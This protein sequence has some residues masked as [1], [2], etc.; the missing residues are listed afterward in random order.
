MPDHS[1]PVAADPVR[2]TRLADYRPPAYLVNRVALAFELHETATR[3]RSRLHLRRDTEGNPPLV[4]D[5]AGQAIERITLDGEALGANRY[6]LSPETL[7]IADVPDAFTL[8]IETTINPRDNT[9]LSGLYLSNGGFFTQCE[10]EGF[11]RITYFPDRPDVMA[12]F[13]VT[14]TADA[15]RCPVM[16]SNGNPGAIE[17]LGD[18]RHRVTWTDPHPKPSYLFALVAGDLVRVADSFTTRS[19]RSV[20]LGIWVRRGDEASCGHAMRSLKAAMAWDEEVF[21]L[22]Y[23]L[24]VFNV[25]A[26]S[27]F[28]MGAMENKGLNVF[29]TKYVLARPETATDGDYEGI[30]TVVA[31]EYFHNWTGNRVTCRDWFQLSL[32]EGLTVYRDQEFTMDRGSRA[33]KR[34]ADVRVLRAAQFREDA[35][36]LAHPVQPDQYIAIDNFYT[37]TVYNKGAEVIRMMATIIGRA[38]FRRGMDLYFQRHDNQAVTIEDFVRCMENA[39][40]TDLSRFRL[41][42]HQA[43]TPELSVSDHYD[44]ATRRYRLSL[45]QRTAPTP[46]Q[47]EKQPQVIPVATGL[48]AQDGREIAPTRVLLLTEA[49]RDFDFEDIP[50]RP[51]PSLLRSFSAPVRLRGMTR[52]QLRLLA[53][54]DTDPF[55]RW[56]SAQQYATA[57]LLG[58][59]SKQRQDVASGLIEAMAAALDRADEDHAFAAEALSLP[60]ESFL[61]DQMEVAAVDA[62]HAARQA[63]RI[64]IAAALRGKLAGTYERLSDTGPYSI[65]GAAI[66]R[67]ALRNAC[68]AYLAA[69]GG[70]DGVRRA[71]AQFDAG[72]NMTDVLAALSVLCAIDCPER[73][74]ALA[75]FHAAWREDALVLDKWFAIQA[76]S[77]LPG[78]VQAV[79]A[80]AAHPD[81]DLRNPN[82]VRA[83]AG[84]FA[85]NQV[86]FHDASGEGYRFL[87]DIIIRLDKTNPQVAARISSPLGQWRRLDAAHGALAQAELRRILAEPGLSRNTREVAG[88]CLDA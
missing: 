86:R 49:A 39:S 14:I 84:G 11:R 29:N 70:A 10:A 26:V 12:R 30:E 68:L 45:R 81:F 37:A 13:D 25:A 46:N 51:I 7:S 60:S 74:S 19:G 16:L 52:N 63:A 77:P 15:A 48:L 50:A 66:G 55:V 32:K 31:H 27:D 22:E 87:A 85:A 35:G 41:W 4:L 53:A 34:I 23:D 76:T 40:G 61:F 17:K 71:K 24:D 6:D 56:D 1:L 8:E 80:L 54:H 38:N 20:A 69:D 33:V 79:R 78:T 82:R 65:D 88:R 59:V 28:N 75:S 43:G 18:G 5:G 21:G 72:A 47:T 73:S 62:I 57:V 67:R 83:L 36:P 2:V 3:V 64:A 44:A 9:E 58:M 42:Y